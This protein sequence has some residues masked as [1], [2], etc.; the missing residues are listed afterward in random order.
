MGL[1]YVKGLGQR[2]GER[3]EAARRE[4]LFRSIADF[5]RRTG[6]DAGNMTR[7][8]EAGALAAFGRSRR[9]ALWDARGARR[10]REP[11]FDLTPPEAE[12][13]FA[14]LS[15]LEE[16]CWDYDASGHSARAH[17]LAPL[18]LEL[19]RQGLPAAREVQSAPDGSRLRYAGLVICRQQPATAK[20]AVFMTL[21][22]ETGF[23]NLILWKDVFSR[24]RVLARTSSFLGVTGRIQ[25]EAGVVNLVGEELWVPILEVRP[26]RTESRDFH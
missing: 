7:L 5:V 24:Y 4:G 14:P 8:A 11:E 17:P 23:V 6:L 25:S 3:I 12:V 16:V 20:G 2:E 1:R 22:D 9:Q 15:V 21:E 10:I 18:R 19:A 13:P 26:A